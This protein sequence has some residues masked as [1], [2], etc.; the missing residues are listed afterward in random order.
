MASIDF[1][2]VCSECG[3]VLYGVIVDCYEDKSVP[4]SVFA[5]CDKIDALPPIF[6]IEPARCPKCGAAFK[7]VTWFA[8]FPCRVP[9]ESERQTWHT[10]V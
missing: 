10:S 9:P 8:A 6:H 7:Q 4:P 3:T 2:P 1:L 5:V